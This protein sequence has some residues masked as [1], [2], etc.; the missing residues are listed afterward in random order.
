MFQHITLFQHIR[1]A[2]DTLI[3]GG[4]L[5]E[6]AGIVASFALVDMLSKCMLSPTRIP[7]HCFEFKIFNYLFWGD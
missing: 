6:E 2:Y 4:A 3:D 7:W 5:K 1:V